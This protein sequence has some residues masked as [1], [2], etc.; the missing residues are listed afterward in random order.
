MKKST[1]LYFTKLSRLNLVM[2]GTV[3][4]SDTVNDIGMFIKNTLA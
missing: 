3:A 2:P 4:I 1:F